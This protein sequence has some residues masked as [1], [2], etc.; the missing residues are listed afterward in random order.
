[1]TVYKSALETWQER[2]KSSPQKRRETPS[3]QPVDSGLNA[4]FDGAA[5]GDWARPSLPEALLK[6]QWIYRAALRDPDMPKAHSEEIVALVEES[7]D[8]LLGT[9][10]GR[11]W[12]E[13]LAEHLDS[14]T[15]MEGEW[16]ETVF[17]LLLKEDP[18]QGESWKQD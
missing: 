18:Y 12:Q 15:Q 17:P 1:M 8:I 9:L 13:T 6:F 3:G 4:F 10:T 14:L 7:A 5:E 2:K 16:K 11:I